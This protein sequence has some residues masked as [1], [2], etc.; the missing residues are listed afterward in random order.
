MKI[1]IEKWYNLDVVLETEADSL[2]E[3]IEKAIKEGADLT[4]ANLRGAD[5]TDANLTDANLRGANLRG[6]NL[7]GADL[8]DASGKFF[9]NY[10][11]LLQ[12]VVVGK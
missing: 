3:A 1:H 6:A 10:G 7:R 5:L 11:V 4:G 9:F 8:T 2:K 12:V